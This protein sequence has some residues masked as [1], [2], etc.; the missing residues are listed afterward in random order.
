MIGRQ[1]HRPQVIAENVENVSDLHAGAPVEEAL[2]ESGGHGSDLS[3]ER[4]TAV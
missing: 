2:S 1:L 4:A 3:G